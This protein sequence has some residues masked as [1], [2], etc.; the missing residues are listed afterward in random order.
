M[1]LQRKLLL[2]LLVANFFMFAPMGHAQDSQPEWKKTLKR[3]NRQ[4]AQATGDL[5]Q[6]KWVGCIYKGKAKTETEKA[7]VLDMMYADE[8]FV[9]S[10]LSTVVISDTTI[11]D[12]DSIIHQKWFPHFEVTTVRQAKAAG[13]LTEEAIAKIKQQLMEHL[14][15]E[16]EYLELVWNYKGKDFHTVA[17]VSN[18]DLWN[19]VNVGLG[20]GG[21]TYIKSRHP[22]ERE[23]RK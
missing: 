1:K 12:T 16:I 14:A 2:T 3:I 8:A 23:S 19:P 22:A 17:I 7:R 20:T 4:N 13:H 10:V 5:R 15:P 11:T 9:T 18:G 21:G 6:L